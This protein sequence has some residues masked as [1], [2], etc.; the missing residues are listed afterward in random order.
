MILADLG[1]RVIKVERPNVGDSSRSGLPGAF[2][3]VNRNKEGLT[4]NLKDPMAQEVLQRLVAQADVL[5]E[6]FRPG[7]VERLGADYATLIAKQPK[8]VYCSLSGYGQYGPYRDMSGYDPN[9][10]AIAGVLSLAG[11]PCGPPEGF[12]GAPI[13]DLA[14]AWFAAISILASL[15]AC[16]RH[17]IGQYIDIAL[18]DASYAL[19]QSRMVEYLVNGHPDKQAMLSRPGIGV[20]ETA[21]SKYLTIGAAEDHFWDA[22]CEALGLDPW[23]VDDRFATNRS[24]REH[25]REIRDGLTKAFLSRPLEEW[26]EV[27]H[28]VGVPTAPVNSL[29][30]AADDPHARARELVQWID[31]PVIGRLPQIRFPGLLSETPATIR[32]RPPLLGEHTDS[33]LRELGYSDTGIGELRAA[34]AV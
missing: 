10:L 1:A 32:E 9:Y 18:G 21:D 13:A 11:D 22:L 15:H 19:M 14:G 8:L 12:V 28:G 31:H 26:L 34:G 27:L 5:V 24:R 20:F 6:G 4:L 3:S 25:G 2:E 7:V 29:G 16:A 30:E 33:I 23:R 17:G